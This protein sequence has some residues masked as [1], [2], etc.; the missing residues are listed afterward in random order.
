MSAP[1]PPRTLWLLVLGFCLWAVALVLLY[2]GHAMGCSFGMP[3]GALRAG[4]VTAFFALL[5]AV[6]WLWRAQAVDRPDAATAAT[7]SFLRDVIV[8]TSAA[9]FASIILT[10]GPSLLLK[11]CL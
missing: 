5:A 1:V 8:W 6:G 7:A 4:L 9:A 3:S 10:L 2:A 11:T